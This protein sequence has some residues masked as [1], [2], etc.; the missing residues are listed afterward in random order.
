MRLPGRVAIVTGGGKGIGRAIALRYH[1]EGAA[2]VV[3]GTTQA[4]IDAIAGQIREGG[5]RAISVNA[6]VADEA[7]VEHLIAATLQ[8]FGALDILVNNAGIMGPTAPATNV[9]LQ[10]WERTLAVNVTGAFLCAKHALPH[11]MERRSGRI[12]NI[13]SVAGLGGY[14][15]RSPY[16]ASKWAMIGLTRSLALE[17][18][19]YNITANAIAPGPIKGD[20]I[21]QVIARRAEEMGREFAEVEREYVEPLALKRMAEEEDIAAMAVFLAS[22]EGRHITGETL[23]ISSGYRV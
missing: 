10:D 5:G 8:E 16:S 14:A 7:Q 3:S 20:R 18:G 17:A 9:E 2:V 1:Q 15:L 19:S 6:D 11:M 12:L 23:N 21:N 4:A 22:E 13:T